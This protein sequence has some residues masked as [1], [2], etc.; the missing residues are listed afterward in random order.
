VAAK[1]EHLW[2]SGERIHE[3]QESMAIFGPDQHPH[4]LIERKATFTVARIDG[5]HKTYD[6]NPLPPDGI[7]EPEH[8]NI[9]H[10]NYKGE[11]DPV[12]IVDKI[13]WSNIYGGEI[14][15]Y[16]IFPTW[17]HWPVAQMPSDGRYA[18]YPD[19]TCHSSLSHIFPPDYDQQF[20]NR[21]YQVKLFLEGMLKQAPLELIPL[22][23]SWIQPPLLSQVKGCTGS[24]DKPQRAYQ[25][26][27]ESDHMSMT[28]LAND[29]KP[30]HNLCLVFKKWNSKK[31]GIVSI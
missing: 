16:A 31:E 28:L 24:Y 30:V 23:R 1:V 8:A 29:E 15:D 10:V 7:D 6:W 25:F 19:R 9:H 20:G 2:T 3:W 17:N 11:Y 22:A 27:A 26:E 13:I 5:A 14:T 21:P 4:D 12:T 18:S